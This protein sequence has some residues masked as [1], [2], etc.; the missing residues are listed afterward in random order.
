MKHIGQFE[1]LRGIAAL[2]VFI[3]HAL[4]ISEIS[5][6]PLG[7]GELAVDVFIVLSG[8]VIAMMIN[9]KNEP[10]RIYIFR[11]WARLYPLFLVALAAGIATQSLY[12]PVL[13][14][15][16]F[17]GV[18]DPVWANRNE[19]VNANFLTNLGLH[20][21]MLHGAVP[22]RVVP[23]SALAFSGP[24]WSISLEWQFY[25][26]APLLVWALMPRRWF[27]GAIALAVIVAG[28]VVA[29]GF[30]DAA[31]PSFLPLKLELFALGIICAHAWPYAQRAGAWVLVV[32]FL[33]GCALAEATGQSLI[34]A[35]LWFG[36]YCLAAA[37]TKW[38]ATEFG[39]RAYTLP[40]L[41]WLGERSYGLYVLH[42][43]IVLM[44]SANLIV[45]NATYLGQI[46]TLVAV[47]ACIFPVLLFAA[48]AYRF[49]EKPAIRWARDRHQSSTQASLE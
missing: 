1:V 46:G 41:R 45:P 18:A 36:T 8:Y 11:R 19:V 31:V 20:L 26:I 27:I 39:N 25:L 43:P 29:S 22:D 35:A 24:L 15:A 3:S 12:D 2:W 28:R 13:G 23:M 21:T 16:L 5:A 48:L 6:G 34:V 42:M 30:W 32:V 7:R 40:P 4:L 14:Q 10:Y 49:I 9:N 47:I 44:I 37:G 17:T 38:K 33:G